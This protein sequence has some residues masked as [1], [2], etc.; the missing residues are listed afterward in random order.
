M[1]F[2]EENL[3]KAVDENLGET[4]LTRY[5]ERNKGSNS[6]TTRKTNNA[7]DTLYNDIPKLF[8]WDTSTKR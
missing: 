7:L 3:E 4:A 2:T 5:F 6:Y 1:V 8:K